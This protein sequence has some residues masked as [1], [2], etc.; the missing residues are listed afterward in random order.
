MHHPQIKVGG[1]VGIRLLKDPDEVIAHL[2]EF[3]E[4]FGFIFLLHDC[5]DLTLFQL[6]EV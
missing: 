4:F 3:K 5:L 2:T 1:F 6:V